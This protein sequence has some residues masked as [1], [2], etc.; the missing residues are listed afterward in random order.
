MAHISPHWIQWNHV[1]TAEMHHQSSSYLFYDF[2]YIETAEQ[3]GRNIE[4]ITIE[5]KRR[6]WK[7][8]GIQEKNTKRNLLEWHK[9]V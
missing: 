9:K 1:N 3:P 8:K 4:K 5:N 6:G 7:F 2:S